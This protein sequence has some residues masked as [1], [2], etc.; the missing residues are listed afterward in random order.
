MESMDHA[1]DVLLLSVTKAHF[2]LAC[3]GA[4]FAK[5]GMGWKIIVLMKSKDMLVM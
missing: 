4:F 1:G 5:L 2:F 3:M